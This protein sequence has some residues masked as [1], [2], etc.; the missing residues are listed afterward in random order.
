MR[1]WCGNRWAAG[2]I[3]LAK[4]NLSEFAA[5]RGAQLDRRAVAEPARPAALAVGILG[6]TGVAIAAAFAVFGLGTDTGGSVRGPSSAN[7]IA[8]P[9]PRS[10]C[11]AAMASSCWRSASTPRA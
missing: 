2:A 4:V 10:G 9:S 1:S 5:G 3:V 7:G 11:S 6:G 8:G